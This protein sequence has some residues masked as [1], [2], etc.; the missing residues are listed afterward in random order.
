MT[1][2]NDSIASGDSAVIRFFGES[3]RFEGFGRLLLSHM[4]YLPSAM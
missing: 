2:F 1:S 3:S 4:R